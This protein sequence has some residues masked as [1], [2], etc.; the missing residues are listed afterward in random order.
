MANGIYVCVLESSVAALPRPRKGWNGSQ[1]SPA[2]GSSRWL[3]PILAH[4]PPAY[5][6]AVHASPNDLPSVLGVVIEADVGG[7]VAWNLM[8]PFRMILFG[9]SVGLSVVG[10]DHDLY[11]L[12]LP[13]EIERCVDGLNG[14]LKDWD[15]SNWN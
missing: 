14:N 6:G 5:P 10:H 4:S 2:V 12:V 9:K 3:D 15:R 7:L 11:V 1:A 13:S 8:I